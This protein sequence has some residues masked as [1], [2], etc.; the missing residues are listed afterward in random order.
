[1]KGFR[2]YLKQERYSE[3]TIEGYTREVNLFSSWCKKYGTT[4]EQ[5]DYKAL[6]KYIKYLQSKS[7]AKRTINHKIGILK[8]YFRYLVFE[9]YRTD[10]PIEHLNIKGA[11]RNTNYNL[12]T[13]E[14]LQ[15]L[16]FCYQTEGIKVKYQQLVAKRNKV[17]V[18]FMVYQGLNTTDLTLLQV[19]DIDIY[20]GRI[21]VKG[22]KRSNSRTLELKSWQVIELLEYVNEIREEIVATKSVDSDRL[23]IP[24]NNRLSI[25]VSA[26]NSKLKT[27]NKNVVNLKQIRAS[28]ITNWLKQ[29]NL[30]LTQ[31]MAG[32]RFISSTERYLQEDLDSLQEL[33][34]LKHP[35]R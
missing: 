13:E 31:Y 11:K 5:I 19:Q 6:L 1:M 27:Y 4:S 32:H 24:N 15:D 26:I 7:L 14:E 25:T 16:Y 33:I 8:S 34:N 22:T 9:N 17:M 12:L 2:E 21:H 3:S 29:H 20:K 23:F 28:V 35:F 30:R 18:G 10:N